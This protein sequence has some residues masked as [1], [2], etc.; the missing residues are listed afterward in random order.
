[1]LRKIEQ[2]S[3]YSSPDHSVALNLSEMF[4]TLTND[5]S[6]RV[7]LGRKYCV[8]EDGKIFQEILK[9]F[10]ELMGRAYIGDYIPWLAWWSSVNGLNAKLDKMAK[11]FDDFLD[12]VVQ[13]HIDMDASDKK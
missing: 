4:S 9:E 5:V 1:M 6:C 2:Q 3:T 10:M 7:A 8:G 11:Q 12:R 13:E